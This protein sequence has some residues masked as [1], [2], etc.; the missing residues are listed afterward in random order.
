MIT[1]LSICPNIGPVLSDDAL[2]G[3]AGDIVCK[4]LPHTEAH[5]AGLLV[6][7]LLRF[8]NIVGRSAYYQV[9]GTRHYPALQAVR[10]GATSKARKG[11]SGDRI[12][13]LYENVSQS[14][15]KHCQHSG[16][17]T[18]EG[19]IWAAR[20]E[21][22]KSDGETV[23]GVKDKRIFVYESEF[24]GPLIVMQRE[25]NILSRTLR[26]SW[27]G[28]PL[29][30]LSKAHPIKA[31]GA[32][33]SIVGDITLVELKDQLTNRELFNGFANRIL[34]THVHRTKKLPFG[35]KDID[36]S[37][38]CASLREAVKIARARTRIF[39]DRNARLMWTRF[40][41]DVPDVKGIIGAIT[42]RGEAQAVRLALI[43]ALINKADH[44]ST[45][46]LKA[47]LSLWKYCENS[48][49]YIF[50]DLLTERQK[51]IVSWMLEQKQQGKAQQ[52]KRAI[53]RGA[54]AGRV[55]TDELTKDMV[56]LIDA[57]FIEILGGDDGEVYQATG[58]ELKQ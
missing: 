10:V 8:G 54:L 3:L 51:K 34:W 32:H 48:V 58:K 47:A 49:H 57:K 55:T 22:V 46:H 1:L 9:E 28:K 11:T 38:E 16:L 40:Y 41:L 33:V 31:T 50:G 17:S 21:S 2:Y 4:L 30:T 37:R 24:T 5:P 14:W 18:G 15:S 23:A 36:W 13:Q 12:S 6:D 43:Y 29:E 7:I 52:N 20:D 56:T 35:G 25:G 45:E 39:M 42:A 44:I 53:I 27:D 26:D 19:I